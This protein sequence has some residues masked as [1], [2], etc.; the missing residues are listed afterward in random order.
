MSENENTPRRTSRP[1]TVRVGDR[2]IV[3]H[4]LEAWSWA[5][6][7]HYA[8][9]ATWPVFIAGF[10]IAYTEVNIL[11]ATL[12]SL[13]DAPIA[14][15]REGFEDAFYFSIETLATVGYGDM[16]PQTR[17]GHIVATFEIFTGLSITAAMTG[18]VFARFSRPRAWSSSPFPCSA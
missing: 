17:Y 5:D 11:Y 16:H 3:A 1:R 12:Y 10:A 2:E 15:A 14:N 9:T 18:L 4:G 13:G 7:Y 8:M 6:I